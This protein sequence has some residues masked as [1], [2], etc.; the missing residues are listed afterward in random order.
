MRSLTCCIFLLL[1]VAPLVGA[2]VT[3]ATGCDDGGDGTA[4]SG[5]RVT[6][7]TRLEAV[8]PG[9]PF[10]TLEGKGW[11][12]TLSQASLA[13]GPLYYFDGVAAFTQAPAPRP[14]WRWSSLL[15]PSVAWAH[16]GHYV[17][18]EA[19]GQVLQPWSADLFAGPVELPAGEGISG[20]YRSG[21]FAFATPTAG[22]AAASLGTSVAAVAGVAEKD[23]VTV[24]FKMSA[25]LATLAARATE[26][27]VEGC[28]FDE[29]DVQQNGTVTVSVTPSVWFNLVD[30]TGVAPGSA[31]APTTLTAVVAGATDAAVI[32]A[33]NAYL[34]FVI[35]LAQTTAYRFRF[36][37]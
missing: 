16:P 6:L 12:V 36:S 32:A 8:S 18:G 7:G 15:G 17:P 20:L 22:P 30:F 10:T 4:T 19:R 2:G 29:V 31:D 3:A 9:E 13:T 14:R 28:A 35:G 37:P 21:R 26:G 34:G 24:H 5:K 33:N 23:G 25:D 11:K 1:T 27:R